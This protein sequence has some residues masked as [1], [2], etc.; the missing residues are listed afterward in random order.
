MKPQ[1]ARSIPWQP[2]ACRLALRG[3]VVVRLKDERDDVPH[4]G[5]VALGMSLALPRLDDDAVDRRIRKLSPAMRVTRAFHAARHVDVPGKR[6]LGFDDDEV[7]LGLSRTFRVEVAP[8]T[9]IVNLVAELSEDD[10]VEMA[11]PHYLSEAPFADDA[12]GP[13]RSA[14]RPPPAPD[15]AQRL[16]GAAEAL[17]MEPGDNALI[18]AIVDSGIALGHPEL[19]G[20]YRAGMDLV[21]LPG[22]DVSRGVVLFG[23]YSARD[24]T[25]E[26]EMGHGTACASIIGA[27]GIGVPP[28]LAGAAQLLPMRALAGARMTDR[29]AP[30]ALGGI[31]DIDAA[32]KCAVDLGARVINLSFGTPATALRPDDPTPHVEV[33]RYALMRDCVLVAASGNSG[34]TTV[35]LPAALPGVIAVGSVGQDRSPSRFST[36]GAHV[37]ISAPGEH[38]H[39]ASLRGYEDDTGTSFAAP[40]VTAAAALLI[41]SGARHGVPLS[42]FMVRDLLVRGASPFAAGADG[43]GCGAGVL[44]VPASLRAAQTLIRASSDSDEEVGGSLAAS[45]RYGTTRLGRFN[46]IPRSEEARN[47]W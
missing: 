3:R 22:D 38:I 24:R 17:V 13:A 23:D 15:W 33:V 28:G 8:E 29:Q 16:I 25:P 9:S 1:V 26:D 36:R 41:A 14:P 11:C 27:R 2:E 19:I 35:Y 45:A 37:A 32:V 7:A 4:Y 10:A 47:Q 21:D 6:H 18:V 44:D 46:A 20:R 31:P 40:F 34:D 12:P 30:T 42:A 39:C 5:D 43:R